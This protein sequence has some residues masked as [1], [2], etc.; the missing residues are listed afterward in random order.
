MAYGWDDLLFGE[1]FWL[2][3]LLIETIL[4]IVSSSVK[5]GGFFSAIFSIILFIVYNGEI[6]NNTFEYYGVILIGVL[7]LFHFFIGTD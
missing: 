6:T 5:Y 7:T 4:L 2:G 3:L 1:G